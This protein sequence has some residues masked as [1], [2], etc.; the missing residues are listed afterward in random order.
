[1]FFDIYE[2]K[3]LVASVEGVYCYYSISKKNIVNIELVKQRAEDESF[4]LEFSKRFSILNSIYEYDKIR[5]LKNY[6]KILK[7]I[8]DISYLNFSGVD[9]FYYFRKTSFFVDKFLINKDKLNSY[10]NGFW[11][12]KK[13]SSLGNIN[14]KIANGA[15]VCFK[16]EM[17]GGAF[18]SNYIF[19]I[20][21]KNGLGKSLVLKEIYTSY[22]NNFN[23]IQV[24]SSDLISQSYF[25][26]IAKN[27]SSYI[28]TS[29][30]SNF[31]NLISEIFIFRK[32][33]LASML[34]ILLSKLFSDKRYENVFVCSFSQQDKL[35]LSIFFEELGKGEFFFWAR[36]I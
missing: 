30:R 23:K 17:K 14:V 35:N 1:M 19:S 9:D 33:R 6:S 8:N 13:I 3:F 24:F 4:H 31:N 15:E 18:F 27:N 25:Y 26:G 22:S 34:F 2:N 36:L 7:T 21:G 10:G 11:G 12:V 29:K 20:V 5:N 32:E 28:N 16:T